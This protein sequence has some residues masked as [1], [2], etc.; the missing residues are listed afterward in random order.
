METHKQKEK[1]RVLIFLALVACIA[2][3]LV[4]PIPQDQRYHHFADERSFFSIPNF[5]NVISNV[6]YFVFGAWGILFLLRER[7]NNLFVQNYWAYQVFF[8]GAFFISFGSAYYHAWPDNDTLVWDRLPMTVAFMGFF[9]VIVGEFIDARWGKILLLPLIILGIFSVLYWIY[10]EHHGRGDLRL[11]AIVQYLPMILLPLIVILFK[12]KGQPLKYLWGM[13]LAYLAAKI[14]EAGDF[15]LFD[16]TPFLSGHTLKH[17]SASLAP[18]F[19][20]LYLRDKMK[21]SK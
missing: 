19:F 2:M 14:F 21:L 11:Y 7:K 16:K 18:L 5:W 4:K 3:W 9:A 12:Q 15:I 1:V 6:P 17:F 10:T 8:I 20:L 13:M